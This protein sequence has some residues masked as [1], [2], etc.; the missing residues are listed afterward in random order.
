[1]NSGIANYLKSKLDSLVFVDLMAG[2]V[3]P[4]SKKIPSEGKTVTKTFPL[5]CGVSETCGDGELYS[6]IPNN[7][8]KSIFFF[9]DNGCRLIAHDRNG[10][11]WESNLRLIGWVNTKKFNPQSCDLSNYIVQSLTTSLPFAVAN[12]SP[13]IGVQVVAVSQDPKSPA[14]FSRYSFNEFYQFLT[15]PYDY[16]AL[17]ITTRFTVKGN[18]LIEITESEAVC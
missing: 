18:C 1:M 12:Y 14:I 11:H 9:E 16:F 5:P 17:N 4:V 7:K 15:P 2:M 8:R 6:L 3:R 10:Q 13:F